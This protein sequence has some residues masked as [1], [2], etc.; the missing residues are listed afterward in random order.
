MSEQVTCPECDGNL[1]VEFVS[2]IDGLD[3]GKITCPRCKGL[4]KVYLSMKKPCTIF[5]HRETEANH[6]LAR[7][8]GLSNAQRDAF[9]YTASEVKFD[10]Y[11]DEHGR[12][13]LQTVNGTTLMEDTVI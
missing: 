5:V 2:K 11:V 9:L 8:L 1:T 10:G 13:W 6:D 4:G 7:N 12:F 3:L